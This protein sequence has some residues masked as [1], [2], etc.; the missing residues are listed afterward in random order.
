MSS[1]E[2]LRNLGFTEADR[3][4]KGAYRAM[5][6]YIRGELGEQDD[7]DISAVAQH[8]AVVTCQ[9]I[10]EGILDNSNANR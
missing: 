7:G 2:D 9:S 6:N 10:I 1:I 5:I 8:I 3:I 4:T